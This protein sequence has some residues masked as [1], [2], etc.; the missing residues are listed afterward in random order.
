MFFH[1]YTKSDWASACVSSRLF[2]VQIQT[3]PFEVNGTVVLIC[4]SFSSEHHQTR[5]EKI[6]ET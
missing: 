5:E 4:V 3:Y 2:Q 6:R 1:V